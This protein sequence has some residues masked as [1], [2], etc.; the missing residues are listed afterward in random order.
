[1]PPPSG[2]PYDAD[3]NYYNPYQAV[4][5]HASSS[6]ECTARSSSVVSPCLELR[7]AGP[8]NVRLQT[9]MHADVGAAS[10]RLTQPHL[11]SAMPDVYFRPS[12][13]PARLELWHSF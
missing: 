1:M 12:H 7:C 5:Q 3:L 8:A 9:S 2:T 10:L 6:F 13:W 11:L 4:S